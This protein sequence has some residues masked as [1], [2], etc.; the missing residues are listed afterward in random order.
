MS[1]RYY[2]HLGWLPRENTRFLKRICDNSYEN[3]LSPGTEYSGKSL[4]DLKGY[5]IGS[6]ILLWT[7]PDSSLSDGVSAKIS[8]IPSTYLTRG[9]I[10][11]DQG[12]W[13]S[14]IERQN[15]RPKPD[16]GLEN[17]LSNINSTKPI[18]SA[19]LG[20]DFCIYTGKNIYFKELDHWLPCN[21]GE[22]DDIG[23]E[24]LFE[25]TR[26][27]MSEES[28]EIV[29]QEEDNLEV[30]VKPPPTNLPGILKK[31]REEIKSSTY[32][33]IKPKKNV[34]FEVLTHD[35]EDQL[36]DV[37]AIKSSGMDLNAYRAKSGFKPKVKTPLDD[38]DPSEG[39]YRRI[40]L[41][42]RLRRLGRSELRHVHKHKQKMLL[43]MYEFMYS[44]GLTA[45][46]PD[47]EVH[48][49]IPSEYIAQSAL[50]GWRELKI[51]VDNKL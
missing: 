45:T 37:M 5:S 34:R 10:T 50:T 40:K 9:V 44:S 22:I 3:L 6:N 7:K 51:A 28:M 33:P 27:M 16:S 36:Y 39:G 48:F 18:Q 35:E 38:V 2:V 26:E 8:S 29:S 21:D 41:S 23:E 47:S 43:L 13:Q 12:N 17:H 30:K 4:Q 32:I 49:H 11:E 15:W 19:I 20:D 25:V 1:E 14:V 31:P 42:A 46:R 24:V